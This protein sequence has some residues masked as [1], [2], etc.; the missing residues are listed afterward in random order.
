MIFLNIIVLLFAYWLYFFREN[1]ICELLISFLPYFWAFFFCFFIWWLIIFWKRIFSHGDMSKLY[2]SAFFL[3]F[4]WVISFLFIYELN[5]FYHRDYLNKEELDGWLKVMYSNI[6]KWNYDFEWIE[7]KILQEDPDVVM[8]VEYSDEHEEW[9]K[10]FV[11]DN[12]QYRDKTNWSK[13]YWWSV[14]YSKYPITNFYKDFQQDWT[15]RYGYFKVE[16]EWIPYYFYLVHTSSPV[17]LGDYTKR[18]QQLITLKKDFFQ[19]HESERAGDSKIIMVWDFNVSPWS[20]FYKRFASA[21]ESK[22]R[23]ITRTPNILFTRNLSEML[24]I[25]KD[26]HF[27]VWFKNNIKKLPILRSHIDQLFASSSVK[28]WNFKKI[29]LNWSDHDGFVFE[30]E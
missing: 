3:I 25:H 29:H 14:V 21:F 18:N 10:D 15:W 23:N 22:M 12:F 2:L 5:S 7:G 13:I 27:P 24:S 17:S 19:L 26:F 8:F 9:L 16:K 20:V 28:V 4:F 6:F 1:Y 30:I 11:S